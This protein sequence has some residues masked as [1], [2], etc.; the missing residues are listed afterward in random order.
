MFHYIVDPVECYILYPLWDYENNKVIKNICI[1]NLSRYGTVSY[2]KN[3]F[4]EFNILLMYYI[5][6]WNI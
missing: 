2:R 3:S 4:L 6:R 1:N 5:V